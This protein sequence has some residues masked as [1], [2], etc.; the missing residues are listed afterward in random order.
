MKSEKEIPNVMNDLQQGLNSVFRKWWLFLIAALLAGIVGFF[1]AGLQKPKYKS[2]LTFALEND[3]N[4]NTGIFSLASQFGINMGN[5]SIF[6]GDNV[7][8]ILTSRRM[9]ENVFLSVDTFEAK[10][11]R[12][13]EYY[14]EATHARKSNKK[15]ESIHFPIDQ[16]RNTFSYQQDS[17]LYSVYQDFSKN[18]LVVQRPNRKQSIYEVSVTTP[19]E[20]FTKCFTDR[21]I[22]ET[23][24]FYIDIRTKK[25]RETVNILEGRTAMIKQDLNSSIS[26]KAAAQDVNINPAFSYAEVPLQKQ[27]ANIQVYGTAYGELFKNLQLARFQYLNSIPLMQIIDPADYPM[28]KIKVSR[29]RTSVVWAFGVCLLI[30]FI[31]W[32]KRVVRLKAARRDEF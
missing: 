21:I 27:Q 24:N 22:A 13:I 31:L 16:Q 28:Q 25:A 10:P 7:L 4:N 1:Y 29:L 32:V 26:D 19:D 8:N 18:N 30:I 9:V 3:R 6:S 5:R 2:H 14:L 20:K 12:L 15:I 23:N 17:L 11:Y